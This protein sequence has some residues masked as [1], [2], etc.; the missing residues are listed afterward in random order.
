MAKGTAKNEEEILSLKIIGDNP[1]RRDVFTVPP[2]NVDGEDECI[3]IG[4]AIVRFVSDNPGVWVFH[5]H[6]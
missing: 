3:D 6:I 2:C 4:F 5:C 1:I